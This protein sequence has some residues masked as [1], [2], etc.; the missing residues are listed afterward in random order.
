M[1]KRI[2]KEFIYHGLG[3]PVVLVGAPMR[4]I[5]GERVPYLDFNALEAA[6]ALAVALKPVRL[7]GSEVRFLR[8]HL[9]L[10]MADFAAL[11]DVTRQAAMKWEAYG[12]GFTRMGW[13]AEKDLRLHVLDRTGIAAPAFRKAF[14]RLARPPQAPKEGRAMRFDPAASKDRKAMLEGCLAAL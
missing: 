10:G 12:A 5:R 6:M 8:L 2:A 9:G 11:F 4:Q 1:S 3:F 14:E 7:T 13:S